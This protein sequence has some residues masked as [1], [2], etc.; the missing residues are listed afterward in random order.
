MQLCKKFEQ[1]FLGSFVKKDT[2]GETGSVVDFGGQTTVI[3][4][5]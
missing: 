5:P 4:T 1:L 2:P 3:T